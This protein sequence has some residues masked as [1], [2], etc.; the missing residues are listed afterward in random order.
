M[1]ILKNIEIKKH[2]NFL[3]FKKEN[4][5]KFIKS[6]AINLE[7]PDIKELDVVF[8]DYIPK[9]LDSNKYC[10]IRE[11][12]FDLGVQKQTLTLVLSDMDNQVVCIYTGTN[13]DNL[14]KKVDS[15][16]F[17]TE[18]EQ[19]PYRAGGIFKRKDLEN[20][21]ETTLNKLKI[22]E[23]KEL[24]EEVI[25]SVKNLKDWD[26]YKR[27]LYGVKGEENKRVFM[28]LRSQEN[29]IIELFI[30][31]TE[32]DWGDVIVKVLEEKEDKFL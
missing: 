21:L 18:M 9:N 28:Q 3:T 8:E 2:R 30:T 4:V 19:T 15:F 10:G 17:K 13:S 6:L 26:L 32:K 31:T 29:N 5:F 7:L 16:F 22:D 20:I 12:T 25:N 1:G 27:N 14:G 23:K 24:I 11:Y